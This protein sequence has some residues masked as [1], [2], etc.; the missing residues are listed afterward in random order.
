MKIIH[1]VLTDG[2]WRPARNSIG[3]FRA[4]NPATGEEL[5][6]FYPISCLAD[7]ED[8]LQAAQYAV[9]G[10][11]KTPPEILADFLDLFAERILAHHDDLVE[12]AHLE[13]ALPK[14]PRL[15]L[16]ELPRTTDQLRQ[17][18]AA[19]RNRSWCRATIDTKTNIRSKYAPLGGPVAVFGP[20][21][22]PF[23]FN[24][25]A[26]GDF[27][28]A[29][30]AGNPVLAKAHP[31]HPAT[32]RLFAEIALECLKKCRL[33][34][35]AIQL[36]YHLRP[37]DGLKLVSHPLLGATAFTGSRS[38]G[39]SLKEAADKAGKPIYIET[40][41]VNPIFL[42]PGALSERADQIAV[43]L[44]NSCSMS[45][46]QF[47]TK[48]GLVVFLRD[49][50]GERFLAMIKKYFAQPQPGFLVSRTV[51]EGIKTALKAMVDHGA[52]IVV[53]GTEQEGPGFRFA[54]TLLRVSGD[55]FLRHSEE[56]EREAFGTV[57]LCVLA[58]NEEQAL[59]IA[60]ALEGSLTGSIY[61]E[62]Q[63]NDDAL[64]ARLEPILRLKVGR[65][66]N[67][68][69]PTG[70]AVVPAMVHGGPYPAAGHPGFT[71]IGIPASLLRFASLRCYDNV[72]QDR[73]PPELRDKNPT[74]KMWRLI[75]GEWT[76]KDI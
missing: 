74:G 3:S 75:D 69:M 64:Y 19:V 15:R 41:S 29:I 54:N 59:E 2:Q 18:A 48:P 34:L 35:A 11:I 23:A 13:T 20:N 14:E 39:L 72:R 45:A 63:G 66:L 44:F 31:N 7:I 6:D 58:K 38:A 76:Q 28:A 10:L 16:T 70:V 43:E 57:S 25:A 22:F 27:A 46:G 68:K 9:P 62:T 17:A 67:D 60:A 37:E 73:L 40:S 65:L 24:A 49:E 33:P 61:S 55:V 51:L 36:I 52:E 47:C 26:G 5:A 4:V 71:S 30:A 53:G 1:P 42:L 32:S 8:A 50:N 12:T 56:F 21:N